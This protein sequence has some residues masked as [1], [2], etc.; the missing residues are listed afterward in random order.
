MPE[1]QRTSQDLVWATDIFGN[2]V[3]G[4]QIGHLIPAGKDSH[5]QWL[6]V[7]CAVLGID[8]SKSAMDVKKKAAAGCRL[9]RKDC[10]AKNDHP[11]T[12]S[13]Q[14]DLASTSR[15]ASNLA[16]GETYTLLGECRGAELLALSSS[17]DQYDG[18][19]QQWTPSPTTQ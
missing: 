7:A 15:D 16:V 17:N 13:Q 18:S 10:H 1:S 14:Q 8:N 19:V 2:K 3:W 4:Q 9:H 5:K 11:I 12:H 6:N